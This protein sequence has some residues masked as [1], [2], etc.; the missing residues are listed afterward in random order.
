MAQS[1]G[2]A[3][4]LVMLILVIRAVDYLY[5]PVFN[6]DKIEQLIAAQNWA[7]GNG[8]SRIHYEMDSTGNLQTVFE[9]LV[10]WPPGYSIITGLLL[11]WGLSLFWA[12]AIPDLICLM[13]LGIF[14]FIYLSGISFQ[15]GYTRLVVWVILILNTAVC[16]YLT[17]VDLVAYTFFLGA[18]VLLS[19]SVERPHLVL[20]VLSGL[21]LGTTV[22]FRY[23][24]I[25]QS[26]AL[27]GA[28]LV[29]QYF[30]NRS[31]VL[32]VWVPALI[33]CA[34]MTVLYLLL[35]KMGN[36]GYIDEQKSGWYWANLKRIHWAFPMDSLYGGVA[37]LRKFSGI[38]GI[39]SLVIQGI[40]TA[41]IVALAGIILLKRPVSRFPW[42]VIFTVVPVNVGLLIYLSLTNAPQTWT[43]EGW[44][45]VQEYRYYAPSWAALF[46]ILT[47]YLSN[48]KSKRL[49]YVVL[50]PLLFLATLETGLYRNWKYKNIQTEISPGD[51][52]IPELNEFRKMADQAKRKNLIP[53]QQPGDPYAS[54]IAE[55]AGWIPLKEVPEN[56]QSLCLLQFESP[57]EIS[58]DL[59]TPGLELNLNSGR[60]IYLTNP[61]H[62]WN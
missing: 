49:E 33:S 4:L 35:Y 43:A 32:K 9:P 44:T 56:M 24:Y 7:D 62:L 11:K 46:L 12:A 34:G 51:L 54:L 30:F 13:F 18:L 20:G 15:W 55:L 28:G 50:L 5:T 14:G 48:Q 10:Q 37:L 59:Q 25:P 26:F 38:H 57:G 45:F 40:A 16:A 17:T 41:M 39:F 21:F 47:W 27:L 2:L 8:V 23:A 58:D 22:W 53:V 36:P 6:P 1:K 29:H 61:P 19:Q 3:I 52:L 42:P 60:T 31:A